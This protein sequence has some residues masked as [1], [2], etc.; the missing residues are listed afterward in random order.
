MAH[1]TRAIP[2]MY[3]RDF[4]S[5]IRVKLNL[6]NQKHHGEFFTLKFFKL[7]KKQSLENAISK[8]PLAEDG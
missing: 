6:Q 1:Y 8:L 3:K 4:L 2:R 5:T 7:E